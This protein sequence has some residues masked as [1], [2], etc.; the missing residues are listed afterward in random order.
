M[1]DLCH[2]LLRISAVAGHK[3]RGMTS[4]Q[5]HLPVARQAL[6]GPRPF[7]VFCPEASNWLNCASIQRAMSEAAGAQ[8]VQALAYFLT[9]LKLFHGH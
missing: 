9:N 6:Q 3:V 2:E 4:I 5:P 8:R 1:Q 7:V